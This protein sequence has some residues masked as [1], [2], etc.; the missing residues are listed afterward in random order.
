MPIEITPYPPPVQL[1]VQMVPIVVLGEFTIQRFFILTIPLTD[2]GYWQMNCDIYNPDDHP[3]S[4]SI[5][6]TGRLWTQWES[7]NFPVD[8]VFEFTMGARQTH[9]CSLNWN[10]YNY[11][12]EG[13]SCWFEVD[14]SWGDKVPRTP[15]TAGFYTGD[16]RINVHTITSSSAVLRYASQYGGK[17]FNHGVWS[18]PTWPDHFIE[19][20]CI[21]EDEYMKTYTTCY[22]HVLALLSGRQYKAESSVDSQD[23][24]E[25]L[26]NTP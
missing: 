14:T 20:D 10:K 24:A 6:V 23:Y 26:F 4:G 16:N 9:R 5:H 13:A 1:D 12:P 17:K 15:W 25:T 2:T 22:W 21:M 18:P 7:A 11:L 19:E 3:A 8:E